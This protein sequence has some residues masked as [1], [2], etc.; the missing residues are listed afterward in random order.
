MASPDI[1]L[2]HH[3]DVDLGPGPRGFPLGAETRADVSQA[4]GLLSNI[5]ILWD[6]NDVTLAT[7]YKKL[8]LHE[9]GHVVGLDHVG[10]YQGR[11]TVMNVPGDEFQDFRG[12]MSQVVTACDKERAR[13]AITRPWVPLP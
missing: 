13:E 1:T 6:N 8:A 5:N 4:T 10:F 9:I 2:T 12:Y 11:A 3:V 7:Y